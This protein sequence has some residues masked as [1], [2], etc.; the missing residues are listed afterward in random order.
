MLT[1]ACGDQT[2]SRA[3]VLNWHKRFPEGRGSVENDELA[4]PPRSQITDQIIT[5]IR[6]EIRDD[7]RL[8]I[9]VMKKLFNYFHF[10]PN[11][12]RALEMVLLCFDRVALGQHFFLP[13][14]SDLPVFFARLICNVS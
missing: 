10:F 2:L 14:S 7:R 13:Y 11:T 5:K 6:D 8:S 3:R 12:A 9:R 1:E 4:G